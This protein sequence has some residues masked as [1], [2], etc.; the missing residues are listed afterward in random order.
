MRVQGLRFRFV[1]EYVTLDFDISRVMQPKWQGLQL[2]AT[3]RQLSWDLGVNG[4]YESIEAKCPPR[5]TPP[6]L[7][8]IKSTQQRAD[9]AQ[10]PSVETL[11]PHA[12]RVLA[13]EALNVGQAGRA[14]VFPKPCQD[15]INGVI[16]KMSYC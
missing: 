9:G 16:T 14:A 11:K 12:E 15:V 6:S 2:S 1:V 5:P 8:A 13:T 4:N 10:I 3:S 7:K